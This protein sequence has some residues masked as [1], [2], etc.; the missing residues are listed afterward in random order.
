MWQRIERGSHRRHRRWTIG[1][2]F[3]EK[4][5]DKI[6]EARAARDEFGWPRDAPLEVAFDD[7]FDI[8][9]VRRAA[10]EKLEEDAAEGVDVRAG[11]DA[12]GREALL[13]RHVARRSE[14]AVRLREA[15]R[16]V[17]L[18]EP[19]VEHLEAEAAGEGAVGEDEDVVGFE[20]AVKD[21]GGVGG[22]ERGGELARELDG[23]VREEGAAVGEMLRERHAVEEVHRD[24]C[25]AFVE[26]AVEDRDDAGMRD[27]CGRGGF[28]EEAAHH[29][30]AVRVTGIEDLER[31]FAIELGV[32]RGEHDA[33]RA[34]RELA[35]EK[36]ATDQLAHERRF[37]QARTPAEERED[38]VDAVVEI[39]GDQRVIRVRRDRLD[40]RQRRRRQ[41][42]GKTAREGP[43]MHAATFCMA[44]TSTAASG[45]EQLRARWR[46]PGEEAPG[47]SARTRMGTVVPTR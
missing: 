23:V 8:T 33:D 22:V 42:R 9:V 19:E 3:R 6:V 29:R 41:A 45:V 13:G 5:D 30:A 11:V 27:A 28:L 7:G 37:D 26:T 24:V 1:G 12:R 31:D 47:R 36:V 46:G 15:R 10:D 38:G 17:D 43:R 18:G 34:L 35:L 32:V 40:P 2:V 4:A 16:F 44:R 14:H 39:V 20:V 21:A 25:A